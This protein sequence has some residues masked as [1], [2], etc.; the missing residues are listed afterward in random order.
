MHLHWALPDALT[1]MGQDGGDTAVPAVPDR[2]L[3]TRSR[4]GVIE[5]QW[6]IESDFLAGPD[7]VGGGV[8]FPVPDAVPYR[9]LGRTLPLA[10]WSP[11]GA[12]ERLAKVTAVGYGE[13]SFAAFYP[14][15]HSVFGFHDGAFTGAPPAGVAYD[16]VGWHSDPAQ[17]VL[18]QITGDDWRQRIG[19]LGWSVPDGAPRPTRIVCYARLAFAPGARIANP[20]LL[21]SRTSDVGVYVGSTATEALAAHLG[22]VLQGMDPDTAENLLEA[23][24]FADELEASPLDVGAKLAEARH[25]ST[26]RPLPSGLLWT[27][28]RQDAADATAEQRQARAALAL[29]HEMGDLLNLLNTAQERYDQAERELLNLREQ[30]FADWY[31]YLLCAYPY[32]TRRDTYPDPD[33]VR[34]YLERQMARLADLT[35]RTEDPGTGIAAELAAAKAAL[36]S[37][38][39]AFNAATA[40]PAGAEY[41]LDRVAAP[42]FYLPSEPV[43]LLT[44]GIATPSD[45]YGHDGADEPG[46]R[47]A[48]Q[49]V[50]VGDP[51]N[52][53]ELLGRVQPLG[54]GVA[55]W[56]HN[57]W[58]P[59]LMQWEVEFF[60]AAQGNNLDPEVHGY[61]STYIT[62]NYDLTP[63]DVELRARPGRDIPDK[64]ANVYTGT[65]VLSSSARPVL[66]ARILRYLASW[67]VAPYNTANT[68]EVS[69]EEFQ[70]AP[71][72]VLDWYAANGTDDRIQMLVTLY[73]HLAADEGDGLSQVLGGL[74][75]ALLMRRLTR[76]LPVA[77]PLGFPDYRRF[78]DQV[79]AA[80]GQETRHAPHPLSDFNPIRAGAMRL[81]RLRVIDNFGIAFP[82][83][84]SD[85]M[86]TT[87]LSVP[88]RSDWVAMLPRLTQPA[89]L[90]A[91]WLDSD[92]E[93][94][95]MND[96][97]TTSPVCGWIAPDDLDGGLAFYDAGGASLGQ[98]LALPDPLEAGKARWRAAPGT[99]AEAVTG[100]PN[101]YLRELA[102]RLR[103]LGPDALG[104]FVTR[105]DTDLAGIEPADYA[106]GALTLRPLAVVRAEVDLRLMGLPAV[107]QDWNVFRQDMRRSSRDTDDAPLV[108]FPV[109]V[110]AAAQLDDGLVA[111][112]DEG[113]TPH[114]STDHPLLEV[115]VGLPARRLT[116]LVDPRAPVHLTS[117]I[118]PAKAIGIPPEQYR[119]AMAALRPAYFV[120]PILTDGDHLAVP[121]PDEPGHEWIWRAR[122]PDPAGW[123][124]TPI[125]DP[126]PDAGFPVAPALREGYLIPRPIPERGTP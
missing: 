78:A 103:D 16:L 19:D 84:V 39:A 60:P 50:S 69:P 7:D 97:P 118:L 72:A 34:H 61:T 113:W 57:P 94:R 104:E 12:G 25:A 41:V 95:Q 59:V 111:Y 6:V 40:R 73:Q 80:V 49:V 75:D 92:H 36:E 93:I 123:I 63:E 1:R 28:R 20:L 30:L 2:W 52:P 116:M 31:K 109:R 43:V 102:G 65:V 17:D 98:L 86:T 56:N 9:R 42:Q 14:N 110:G 71:D 29:T 38:L 37:A 62:A 81:R 23:I 32:E 15:C 48:C 125:D 90:A 53:A 122:E 66:S 101:P 33:E 45:R 22:A 99:G 47:L 100:I 67:I 13:P 76:Q 87:Q 24:S 46:G 54:L 91:R 8:T 108:R 126:R 85:P 11:D 117:G 105:L 21:A 112:W 74:N 88:G 27:V 121:V 120:A 51:A 26:F 3:V 35:T 4:D 82:I 55:G 68:T 79:A 114:W 70:K 64:G 115:A 96:V 5:G 18:A 77:D 124:E 119:D 89:Q 58:H 10:A 83:D 107:H 106:D 44:G